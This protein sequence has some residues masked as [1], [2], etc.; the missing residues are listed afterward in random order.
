[1]QSEGLQDGPCVKELSGIEWSKAEESLL[2]QEEEHLLKRKGLRAGN[3][4]MLFA[5]FAKIV[6]V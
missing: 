4:A 6:Q 2:R 5:I 1:M 3:F